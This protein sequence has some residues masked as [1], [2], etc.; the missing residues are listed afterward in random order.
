MII[1]IVGKQLMRSKLRTGLTIL[2]ISI[3]ILLFTTVSSFSEGISSTVD[4]E[5]KLL[6]GKVTITSEGIGFENFAQSELE[7][8]LVDEIAD[9]SGVDR[10]SALVAGD[11]PGLGEVYGANIDDIDLFD[12][13]VEP[14]EG[15]W[16]DA[17]AD[18]VAFGFQYAEN[19]D[20]QV[21]DQLE[22]RGKRY[23]IVGVIGETG[24]EEDT[25]ILTTFETSKEILRKEDKVTIIMVVPEN[26]EEV[27]SLANDLSIEFPDLQ[28]L[29]EKDAA[30]EAEEFTGSLGLTTFFLGLIS[31]AIAA[32]GIT[33]V[34]FMS[35]RERRKEIGVMKALGATTGDVLSQ[36]LAEALAI[37]LTGAIIGIVISFGITGAINSAMGATMAKITTELVIEVLLFAIF[38]GVMSGILPA[39][40]AAKLQ[41]AVVL[42]YE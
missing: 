16:P 12:I 18:E 21:G 40:E 13:D 35:V 29:T 15:R 26:V 3:A 27:E 2:G 14:E 11:V 5:L 30:R 4:S 8:D 34:M 37:T 41:P 19:T 1:D 7:E 28:I 6:S 9:I 17:D 39:R 32:L 31:A 24:S 42:R 23:D 25:G 20:L 36:I 38:L 22:I 33:N 10:V